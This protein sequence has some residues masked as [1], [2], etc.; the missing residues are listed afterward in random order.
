MQSV[1]LAFV[2]AEA[3]DKRHTEPFARAVR[4]SIEVGVVIPSILRAKLAAAGLRVVDDQASMAEYGFNST[5]VL[6]RVLV[7][8]KK[9]IVAMGAAADSDEALL[10]SVL[11]WFREHPAGATPPSGFASKRQ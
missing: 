8:E 9:T 6:Q 10:A 4:A 2:L 5:K 11:G 1:N 3:Q 7:F